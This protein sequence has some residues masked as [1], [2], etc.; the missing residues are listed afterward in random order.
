MEAESP[1][2]PETAPAELIRSA[3]RLHIS[4]WHGMREYARCYNTQ[5]DVCQYAAGCL[6]GEMF[7][8]TCCQYKRDV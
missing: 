7:G 8:D 5:L 1:V 3:V 2:P 6:Q 4:I